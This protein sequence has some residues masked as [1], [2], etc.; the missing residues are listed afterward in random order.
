MMLSMQRS[1]VPLEAK[2]ETVTRAGV[3]GDHQCVVAVL[4]RV[5]LNGPAG[6]DFDGEAVGRADVDEAALLTLGDV[7]AGG[8]AGLRLV[9]FVFGLSVVLLGTSSSGAAPAWASVLTTASR[10]AVAVSRVAEDRVLDADQ[11]VAAI[12]RA[13][14]EVDDERDRPTVRIDRDEDVYPLGT[15]AVA[16][17]DRAF[18][19]ILDARA[20]MPLFSSVLP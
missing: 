10:L 15:L 20:V 16:G 1:A 18:A 13:A 17:L 12:D 14:L 3:A 9:V 4:D 5:L 2:P 6:Q 19:G 7:R 8:V 11:V